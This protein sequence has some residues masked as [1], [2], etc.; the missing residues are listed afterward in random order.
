MSTNGVFFGKFFCLFDCLFVCLL[1]D[2]LIGY[3]S[4]YLNQESYLGSM[5]TKRQETK[6]ELTYCI[7]FG[8]KISYFVK[9][10]TFFF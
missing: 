7:I 9:Y 2:C 8:L 5:Q 10:K 3:L 4:Y 6:A 1:F